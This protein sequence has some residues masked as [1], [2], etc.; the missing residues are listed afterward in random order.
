MLVDVVSR[1]GNLMLNFPLPNSGMLDDQELTILDEIT[2]WMAV[3]SEGIYAT[4]PWKIFG[5]GPVATAPPSGRGARF[6]EAGRR[7]LTAEE[8]RFTTKG[9]TLYAF[10]MGWPQKQAVIQPLATTSVVAQMQ[11]KNVELLGF[12]GKVKWTQD[13]KGLA[14][15]L[16]EQ[17]PCDHAIALKIAL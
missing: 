4:R 3:N 2:R 11:I 6:N 15:E 5:D 12:K 7:D 9:N 10:V 1:N 8:V 16:P 17:K 14:V 13:D